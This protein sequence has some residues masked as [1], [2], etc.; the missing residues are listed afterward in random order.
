MGKLMGKRPHF[1]LRLQPKP[2][3][4]YSGLVGKREI[5]VEAGAA[6]ADALEA[7][8]VDVDRSVPAP[9]LRVKSGKTSVALV[10]RPETILSTPRAVSVI[11][12]LSTSSERAQGIVLVADEVSRG[13]RQLLM[14]AG[15]GWLD[16]RGSLRVW[17][18]PL[19]IDSAIPAQPRAERPIHSTDAIRGR[20]GLAFAVELLLAPEKPP[21]LTAIARRAELALSSVSEGASGV[22]HAGR[23]RSDGRP[24]IPELFASVA[25]A[26]RPRWRWLAEAPPPGNG[27]R[28]ESL[29]LGL[30]DLHEAGWALTDNRAAAGWGAALVVSSAFPPALYVPQDRL[31]RRALDLFGEGTPSETRGA[32][33]AVAPLPVVCRRRYDVPGETWPGAH[34]LFVALDLAQDPARGAEALRQW[35]PPAPFQRVW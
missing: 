7:L 20:G 8:W 21:T 1:G 9:S 13:A 2:E 26:W 15:F 3:V 35:Q 4:P 34:P 30:D 19:M 6:L 14:E 10:A 27:T 12:E 32:R 25:E 17:V 5:D 22:R 29:G 23:V 11:A 16:R 31:L 24:L 28:T 18:P 33:V